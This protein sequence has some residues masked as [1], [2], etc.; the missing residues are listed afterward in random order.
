MVSPGATP[1]EAPQ[2]RA[3][4]Y[5]SRP[6]TKTGRPRPSHSSG[7]P[8][9][10]RAGQHFTAG[11]L[12]ARL[13]AV[14][15]RSLPA[16]HSSQKSR[17]PRG[18]GQAPQPQG[19]GSPG[20]PRQQGPRCPPGGVPAARFSQRTG[21]R[22]LSRSWHCTLARRGLSSPLLLARKQRAQAKVSVRPARAASGSNTSIGR[23][24]AHKNVTWAPGGIAQVRPCRSRLQD[25]YK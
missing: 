15:A 5:S 21:P 12:S 10:H 7:L 19:N 14:R 17:G 20:G 6:L 16:A 18:P 9:P 4:V 25:K 2:S 23:S 1:G 11:S 13:Q 22:S 3:T 24:P 8:P